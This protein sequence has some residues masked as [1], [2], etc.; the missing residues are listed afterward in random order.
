M[1][2]F[3]VDQ[4]R[5]FSQIALVVYNYLYI[6]GKVVLEGDAAMGIKQRRV[7]FCWKFL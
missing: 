2:I 1:V 6:K 4:F 7:A 3:G 5:F